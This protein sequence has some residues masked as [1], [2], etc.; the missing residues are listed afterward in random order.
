MKFTAK[1]PF[2][3]NRCILAEGGTDKNHPGENLP[4]KGPPDE[5]PWTNPLEQL[6]ENMYRGFCP[7]FCTRPTINLGFEMCEVL[8]GVPGSVTKCDR[9][10]GVIIG[11]K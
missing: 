3:C 2:C 11:Q 9:G 7:G 6:R 10:E 4:V 8:L 1:K 5:S